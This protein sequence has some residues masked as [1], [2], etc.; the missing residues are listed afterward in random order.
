MGRLS[1]VAVAIIREASALEVER[2]RERTCGGR[3]GA[4]PL[5][6]GLPIRKVEHG[7]K[8]LVPFWLLGPLLCHECVFRVERSGE[9]NPRRPESALGT[10]A[11][12]EAN[13]HLQGPQRY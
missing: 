7:D 11:A 9:L 8:V 2:R 1:A 4:H 10:T 3:K 13:P 12:A 5:E 6:D